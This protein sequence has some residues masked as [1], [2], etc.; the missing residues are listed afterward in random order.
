[1]KTLKIILSFFAMLFSMV[2]TSQDSTA[3]THKTTHVHA[4]VGGTSVKHAV[5]KKKHYR[6]RRHTTYHTPASSRTTKVTTTTTHT[7]KK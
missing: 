1:M 5:K 6:I 7:E 3:T 4:S 2:A